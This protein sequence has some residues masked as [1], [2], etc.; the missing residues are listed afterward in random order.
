M[1][2]PYTNTCSWHPA[3]QPQQHIGIPEINVKPNVQILFK[4]AGNLLSIQQCEPNHLREVRPA[5]LLDVLTRTIA[6]L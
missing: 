6:V 3:V 4:V 2:V 1:A 5:S